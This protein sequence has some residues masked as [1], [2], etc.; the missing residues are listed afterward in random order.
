MAMSL[1]FVLSTGMPS[2]AKDAWR[3]EDPN[4]YAQEFGSFVV[5]YNNGRDIILLE[6]DGERTYGN[7]FHVTNDRQYTVCNEPGE[8]LSCGQT[9]EGKLHGQLVLPYCGAV[10]E[11][12]IESISIGTSAS[13]EVAT[14]VGTGFGFEFPGDLERGIPRGSGPSYFDSP[15][16]HSSG[17]RYAAVA[18]LHFFEDQEGKI[19][20][21]DLSVRVSPVQERPSDL[22]A[23]AVRICETP[24]GK[25][26]APCGGG[27]PACFYQ[28]TGTCAVPQDFAANQ[29]VS[30]TLRLGNQVSG[31][32]RGRL[33]DPNIQVEPINPKYS[34]VQ[35]SGEPVSV[36]RLVN[37]YVEGQDG[38]NFIGKP[39]EN[40]H[41]G[42]FTI[43]RAASAK[44]IDVVNGLR[45]AAKDT[46]TAESSIWMINSI[47]ANSATGAGGAEC[48]VDT[49]KLLGIVT[50]NA[51]AFT[52]TVPEYKSG[53]LSYRVAGMHYLP[54]GKTEAL[55][56]YDLVM[57]SDVA[58]CL[59]GFSKAPVSATIQVVG[60]GGE[61]K[62]ATTIVSERDG[63][64]KLAAYGFTFSEKEI[65]VTL[66]QVK[67]PVPKTLNLARFSGKTTYLRLEQRWA[68]QDFVKASENT[69]SVT[70]TSMYVS[71]RDKAIALVRAKAACAVAKFSNSDFV[72]KT[73]VK[74]TK[75]KSLDGRVVLQSR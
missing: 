15:F 4:F 31:W 28:T 43:F 3:A 30:V 48:L 45:G 12:C 18:L 42:A 56:T 51:M 6:E 68:I 62:V 17:N 71:S 72:V 5:D 22:P 64:L 49:S 73:A 58:R 74:Q 8:D 20:L 47:S 52:G 2:Q 67:V 10:V 60:L 50:T 27:N 59:Y 65:R 54:D 38:P 46:A 44:G 40:S 36:P 24:D 33:L 34:K 7:A 16:Q 32:F 41:G 53:Y 63:W 35:V 69:K 57:R 14:F 37:T 75:T 25:G 13:M 70:C 29:R 11:S 26:L 1:A 39:N 55:G 61:E 9:A 66:D 21:D 19:Q 23:P